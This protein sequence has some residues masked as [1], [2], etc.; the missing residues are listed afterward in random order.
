MCGIADFLVIKNEPTKD[1][2]NKCLNLMQ[3]SSDFQNFNLYNF[4]NMC[5]QCFILDCL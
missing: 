3:R 1:Q 5:S 4:E 2:I